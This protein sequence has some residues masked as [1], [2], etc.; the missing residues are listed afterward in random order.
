[1]KSLNDQITELLRPI[2]NSAEIAKYHTD[3]NGYRSIAVDVTFTDVE[4]MEWR[5]Y[6]GGNF[7]GSCIYGDSGDQVLKK[8]RGFDPEVAR[9]RAIAEIE[10]RLALL[11]GGVQ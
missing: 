9:Q 4:K 5:I 10:E 2:M 1:M 6:P 3:A 7:A 8:I 11:K